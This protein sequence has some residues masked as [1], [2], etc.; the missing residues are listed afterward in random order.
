MR[1]FT[2]A[3]LLTLSLSTALVA[4]CDAPPPGP[5]RIELATVCAATEVAL[6]PAAVE[7]D[8]SIAIDEP[9]P[10]PPP[11]PSDEVPL[12]CCVSETGAPATCVDMDYDDADC[13]QVAQRPEAT[14]LTHYTVEAY[15]GTAIPNAYFGCDGGNGDP[16]TQCDDG[17]GTYVLQVQGAVAAVEFVSEHEIRVYD[18]GEAVVVRTEDGGPLHAV[19][20]AGHSFADPSKP[21]RRGGVLIG[22]ANFQTD[23]L[24][25]GCGYTGNIC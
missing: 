18:L 19:V 13:Q 1:T 9:P 16:D 17:D 23:W 4:A 11:P 12:A 2:L 3:S 6:K 15:D 8:L 20:P 14:V 7:A 25:N 21:I 10:P 22:Y 24:P 5:A